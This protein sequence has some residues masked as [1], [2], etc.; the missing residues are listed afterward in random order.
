MMTKALFGGAAAAAILAGSAALAQTAEPAQS[1][2]PEQRGHA[3][4]AATR[5]DVQTHVSRFFSRVDTNKDGFVNKG[6]L[7]ALQ[8]KRG[9]KIHGREQ[10]RAERLDPAKMFERLDTNKDGVISRA[11]FDAAPRRGGMRHAS[12]HDGFGGRIFE[13]ADLNKDGRVSLAEAQQ[14]ALQHF[15]QAD[16]NHD[17]QLTREERR[18]SRQ[19]LRGQRQPS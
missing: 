4:K 2:Q 15:D 10:K 7:D 5:T 12:R 9:D 1:P 6:E 13:T 14:T 16:L 18:Q 8:T 3:T 19:Q 11:E 17:G